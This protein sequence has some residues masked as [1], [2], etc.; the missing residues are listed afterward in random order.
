[1]R[2]LEATGLVPLCHFVGEIVLSLA[3]VSVDRHRAAAG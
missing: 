1:M 2:M 3:E